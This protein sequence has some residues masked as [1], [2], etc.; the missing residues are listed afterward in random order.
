MTTDSRR[1]RRTDGAW[2]GM[3]ALLLL[4][5]LVLGARPA[6]AQGAASATAAGA[7][8]LTMVAFPGSTW[9]DERLLRVCADPENL[10]FSS[11]DLSGFD[12]RIATL[13]A[14]ELGDSLSYVWW[15]ARRGY[16]RNT[17]RAKECDVVVG[18]PDN[19]D[20]VMPTKPYYRSTYVLVYPSAKHYGLTS[21]D[22]P[23]LRTLRIGVNLIGED[24][25]HTPPVHA[26]LKRGISANVTGFSTF[27]GEEHHPG[28]IIEAL[29][30]GDVDVAIAWGPLAGYFAQRS[31]VPLTL[32]PLPDDTLS[33]M[34]FA[35]EVALGV[36]RSDRELRARLDSILVQRHDEIAAILRDYG[37][38]TLDSPGA[39]P[40]AANQA[41]DT[42]KKKGAAAPAKEPAR[43][44]ARGGCS[45]PCGCGKASASAGS[46]S[47]ASGTKSG[48][49]S[50]RTAGAKAKAAA[51]ARTASRD[52]VPRA[53]KDSTAA[54]P[55]VAQ[56]AP[57]GGRDSLAVTQAE[58]NG[59]KTFA[60]NCTR[61][62]G[63][64][65]FGTVIAP[66]LLHSLKTTVPTHDF[67][68]QTVTEGRPA[69]GMPT[70]GPLLEP[71]RIEELW[72]YLKARSDGRLAPGRPHVV[73]KSN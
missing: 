72:A 1:T 5:L 46:S 6:R 62:H 11:R 51:A 37:V 4:T 3:L 64:D 14:R 70:W 61:C 63:D 20:P 45:D 59:W 71:Q 21:L 54:A 60:V 69:K 50:G 32:V 43:A 68:V 26:L 67:F 38:P 58:Y 56:A 44:A 16:V 28:E 42:T 53:R 9:K 22:D 17:L 8:G 47:S 15:P 25:T 66:N 73:K 7:P 35:F 13:I 34:P 39:T 52:T 23:Q 65:A 30:R 31:P 29:E 27:Y 18:V 49:A 57:A 24:Y 10:P 41:Q 33:G 40:T 48:T 55:T 12:N 2:L 36:R 19:Y